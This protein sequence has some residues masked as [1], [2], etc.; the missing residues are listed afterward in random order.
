[1]FSFEGRPAGTAGKRKTKKTAVYL[2]AG[3]VLTVLFMKS[4]GG[5]G[6]RDVSAFRGAP[7]HSAR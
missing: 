5:A 3:Y 7:R 6:R 2:S 1:M 4:A